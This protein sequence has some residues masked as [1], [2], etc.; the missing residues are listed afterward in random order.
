MDQVEDQ[1]VLVDQVEDQAALEVQALHTVDQVD[2]GA[3]Q[4]GL[5]QAVG[6]TFDFLLFVQ[7]NPA[8]LQQQEYLSTVELINMMGHST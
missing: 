7:G 1:V 6:Q 8:E 5:D 3:V 4:V 2:L